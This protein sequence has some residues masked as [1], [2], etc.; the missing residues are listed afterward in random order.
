MPS[1]TS[2]LELSKAV[3]QH[4][5]LGTYPDNEEVI[6]AELPST[7]LETLSK[8]LDQARADVKVSDHNAYVMQVN[9]DYGD[10]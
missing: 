8:L 3:Y 1:G 6:S 10:C 7:A 2:D 5:D 4:V 9:A